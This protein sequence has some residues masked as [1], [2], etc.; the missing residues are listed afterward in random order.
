[1]AR[2]TRT[3]GQGVIIYCGRSLVPRLSDGLRGWLLDR[4]PGTHCMRM[5]QILKSAGEKSQDT[6]LATPI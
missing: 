6:A 4:E 3:S 2:R 1:M 5:R